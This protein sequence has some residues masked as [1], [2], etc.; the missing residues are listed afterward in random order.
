MGNALIVCHQGSV[1]AINM[2]SIRHPAP[3]A[4]QPLFSTGCSPGVEPSAL[5]INGTILAAVFAHSFGVIAEHGPKALAEMLMEWI[6]IAR[7]VHTRLRGLLKTNPMQCDQAGNRRGHRFY[8]PYLLICVQYTDHLKVF[9]L[10]G[11]R[12][13]QWSIQKDRRSTSIILGHRVQPS[14]IVR[15]GG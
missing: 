8:P 10:R 5:H 7:V 1:L 12:N 9:R 2:L 3:E 11:H 4:F 14:C 13:R 15:K 6:G